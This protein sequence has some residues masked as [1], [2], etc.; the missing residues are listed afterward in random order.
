[1]VQINFMKPSKKN[2]M[3][4]WAEKP[5]LFVVLKMRELWE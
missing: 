5:V 2:Y 1:M 3:K 4:S